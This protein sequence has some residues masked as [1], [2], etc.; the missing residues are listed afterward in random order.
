M[1]KIIAFSSQKG[2]AGKTTMTQLVATALF[3][4]KFKIIVYDADAPQHS[5]AI[6]RSRDLLP[7]PTDSDPAQTL[8]EIGLTP[9]P[10]SSVTLEE[11][12]R[13]LPITRQSKEYEFIFLDLP[14]TLNNEYLTQ[15]TPFI[16]LAIIPAELEFKSFTAAM[17]TVEYF[18]V[19][20]PK[21]KLA[22]LWTK[23][24]KVHLVSHREALENAFS[25][26][27]VYIFQYRLFDTVKIGQTISTLYPHEV[28]PPFIAELF[29]P[30][31]KDVLS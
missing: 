25:E 13:V 26:M 28:I 14:G 24:K 18:K 9:Y 3:A 20:S 12:L 19:C 10:V 1:A 21:T 29:T 27:G 11:L 30:E 22:M 4:K 23:L 5:F 17:Q 16:D 15:L 2:G 31:F 8:K 6:S 7:T